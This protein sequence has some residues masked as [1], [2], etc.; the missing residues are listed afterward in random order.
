MSDDLN[1]DGRRQSKV[2]N[3]RH[4]VGRQERE[5]HTRK[6]FRQ[7]QAKLVNV[8]VRRMVLRGQGH[9]N[10]RIRRSHRRRIAV[11]E[12]D[13]AIWQADVINDALDLSCRNLL[14]NRLLDL[15]AKVGRLFNSHSRR[16]A[17][18]KLESAA[19]HAGKEIP[20]QPRNQNDHRADTEHEE[21]NQKNKPVM[22]TNLQQATKAVPELLEGCLKT[23][24]QAHERIAAGGGFLLFSPQQVLYHR[25][26]DGPR[27]EIRS[28]HGEHYRFGERN[29]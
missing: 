28:Q 6:L 1:I 20:A 13:T 19:V 21:C 27:K 4:H 12:I 29:E 8:V 11:G 25:W 22:E 23:L 18:V 7:C 5:G 17:H 24:L 15:V 2:E 16:S 3:L 10:V 26:N 14:S 9:K